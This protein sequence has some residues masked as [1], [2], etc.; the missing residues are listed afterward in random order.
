[1]NAQMR[2]VIMLTSVAVSGS[3]LFAAESSS[4]AKPAEK[5]VAASA[6]EPNAGTSAPE[7]NAE[8]SKP[9][10]T[11]DAPAA[12]VEASANQR[13]VPSE[14]EDPT[15]KRA[16]TAAEK[17]AFPQRFT[18]SRTSARQIPRSPFPIQI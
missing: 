17:S 2:L 10:A 14:D 9:E 15:P 8:A 6:P 16:T 1:M 3:L 4:P 12:K 5:E 7:M 13:T 11:V 18:P